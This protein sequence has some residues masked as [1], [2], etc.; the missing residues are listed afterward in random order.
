MA[1]CGGARRGKL[2][3]LMLGKSGDLDLDDGRLDLGTS[4]TTS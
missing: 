2:S 3:G 4:A 1:R